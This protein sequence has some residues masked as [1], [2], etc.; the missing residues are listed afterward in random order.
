MLK[1]LINRFRPSIEILDH[2]KLLRREVQESIMAHVFDDSIAD[3]DWIR[4]K[5]FSPHGAAANYSFLYI[6]F[7]ILNDIKPQN[8]LELGMGQTSKLTAQYI[9]YKNSSA[10]LHLVEHDLTWVTIFRNEVELSDR[11]TIHILEM[12]Q[13]KV[14]EYESNVYRDLTS[15]VKDQKFDVIIN[16]GPHGSDHYSRAGILDLL[17]HNLADK[18][19]IICD[20]YNWRSV[21]ETVSEVMQK[22][23]HIHIPFDHILYNG[24][25]TQSII[26]S[27]QYNFLKTL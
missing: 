11:I 4:K 22:L 18:F 15:Q 6:L 13:K 17:D 1:Q 23:R 27:P 10:R 16:D 24:V 8:I 9:A 26:Y 5:S 14:Q 7:R 3:V 2:V 21:Q 20:D 25:K 19:V 12:I